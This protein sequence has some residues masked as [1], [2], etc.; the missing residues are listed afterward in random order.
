VGLSAA[1]A[2]VALVALVTYGRQTPLNGPLA[3]LW[4][5]EWTDVGMGFGGMSGLDMIDQGKD[6]WAISDR[7]YL[8]R[9]DLARDAAGHIKSVSLAGK[10]QFHDSFGRPVTGF[11]SDTEAVRQDADGSILVAFEGLARVARFHPPDMTPKMLHIWDRFRSIWGNQGLESLA[12]DSSGQILAILER[13]VVGK[14][15][16]TL[17]YQGGDDWQD[18]PQ[19]PSDGRFMATDA[20]YGPDG[21]LYVLERRFS[22]LWGYTTR[23]SAY[24][25]IAGGYSRPERILQTN[26]GEYADFEGLSLWKDTQGRTIATLIS[27][28][29]FLPFTPTT[30][31]EFVVAN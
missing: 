19:L 29:N 23:I 26:A 13:P 28:N 11:Q 12:I 5:T 30:I 24:R 20:D 8:F 4:L 1:V 16:R 14:V 10:Y 31:A 18:G 17:V 7:G 22:I 2:L 25:P 9:A 6:F 15:Y 27:D 3:P 21:R